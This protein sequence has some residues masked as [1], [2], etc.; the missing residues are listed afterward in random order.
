LLW[1]DGADCVRFNLGDETAVLQ[2]VCKNLVYDGPEARK[3]SQVGS[4]CVECLCPRSEL[5]AGTR[6]QRRSTEDMMRLKWEAE[7][8]MR[9]APPPLPF[10][11]IHSC[12]SLI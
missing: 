3:A 1:P 4:A 11:L 5:G 7:E 6:G 10:D 9:Y 8:I 12:R 2:I